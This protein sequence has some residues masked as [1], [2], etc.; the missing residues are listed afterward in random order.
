M[1]ELTK[2]ELQ[3]VNGGISVWGVIGLISGITFFIGLIDG[4]VRPL[5]CN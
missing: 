4:F 2:K 1:Q 3:A 5:K